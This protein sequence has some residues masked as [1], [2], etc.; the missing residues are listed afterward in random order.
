M[1]RFPALAFPGSLALA[2][3]PPLQGKHLGSD[4]ALQ[5][6]RVRSRSVEAKAGQSVLRSHR[7]TANSGKGVIPPAR[8]RF[9]PHVQKRL[10]GQGR[11]IRHPEIAVPPVHAQYRADPVCPSRILCSLSLSTPLPQ[12]ATRLSAGEGRDSRGYTTCGD[13]RTLRNSPGRIRT[14]DQSVNSR[15]LYR[16]SYRGPRRKLPYERARLT[17]QLRACKRTKIYLPSNCPTTRPP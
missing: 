15:P 11:A 9:L 6:H 13:S 14:S 16:L 3:L 10:C 5:H 8:L 4:H 2:L 17:Q 12:K 7:S 1:V